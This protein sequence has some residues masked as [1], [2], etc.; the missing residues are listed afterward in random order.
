MS[1]PECRSCGDSFSSRRYALG[2]KT[3]LKC[4]E[5]DAQGHIQAKRKRIMP[6]GNKQGYQLITGETVQ[7]MKDQILG[8]TGKGKVKGS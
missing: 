2:Y 6:G 5:K 1:E 8:R 4:G 3:C 7:E